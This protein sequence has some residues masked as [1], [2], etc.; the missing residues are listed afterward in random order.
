MRKYLISSPKLS[1]VP[2]DD[3]NTADDCGGAVLVG[4]RA[5]IFSIPKDGDCAYR[6]AGTVQQIFKN[7]GQPGTEEVMSPV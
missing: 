5:S 3:G 2:S 4:G 1:I 7:D 6:V